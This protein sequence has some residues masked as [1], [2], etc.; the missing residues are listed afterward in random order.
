MSQA[1]QVVI[2][3]AGGHAREIADIIEARRNAGDAIEVIGYLV[4]AAYGHPGPQ[5]N[6]LPILGGIDW[7]ASRADGVSVVCGIGAPQVRIRLVR[8][9]SAQGA[10]F[11]SAIHPSAI[12]GRGVTLGF[13]V[14]LA[15]GAVVTNSIAIG[16]HAHINVASTVSHDTKLGD[17]ATLSPGVNLSGGVVVG[18][19][20]MIGT[21]ATVLPGVRIGDWSIVGAGAVVTKDVAANSTAAGVPARAIASRTPGW[22]LETS[23]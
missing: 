17:F 22:H 16:D 15:A 10:Q 9:A 2:I 18:Q 3:G 4:E 5:P 8:E 21:G 14:V 20:S 7:L 13:G 6:D 19:G 1:R 12:Q 23:P 11:V